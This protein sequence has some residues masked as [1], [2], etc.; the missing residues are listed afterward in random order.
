MIRILQMG[1]TNNQG[2]IESFL[3]NY[4]RNID[5]SKIQFDFTNIYRDK[6]CYQDEIEK[7]GGKVYKV[8]NK[9]PHGVTQKVRL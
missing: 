1:M 6:L 8:G 9:Y 5:K 4:Y 7:S 3:I 2:G